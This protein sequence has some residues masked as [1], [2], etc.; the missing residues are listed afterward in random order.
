MGFIWDEFLKC[1]C[2]NLRKYFE[3]GFLAKSN[4]FD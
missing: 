3:L 4:V 1:L 2:V